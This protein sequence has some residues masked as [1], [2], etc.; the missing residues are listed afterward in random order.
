MQHSIAQYNFY[1]SR[2]A[3]L[4]LRLEQIRDA[5]LCDDMRL[6]DLVGASTPEAVARA[7]EDLTDCLDDLQKAYLAFG[8]VDVQ[9]GECVKEIG[10]PW[11]K[12]AS[13]LQDYDDIVS[14]D[15]CSLPTSL[16]REA[17]E[18]VRAFF[19]C[20]LA[21]S[22]CPAVGE[23][24][25][26][27][28]RAVLRATAKLAEPAA[29]AR[30][31]SRAVPT[32]FGMERR[33]GERLS[34]EDLVFGELC[35][36]QWGLRE[37][38]DS[39]RFCPDL[40]DKMDALWVALRD[41]S[42]TAID[43]SDLV[44]EVRASDRFRRWQEAYG[45]LDGFLRRHDELEFLRPLAGIERAEWL[46]MRNSERYEAVLAGIDSCDA[47]RLSDLDDDP[48][49]FMLEVSGVPLGKS[50]EAMSHEERLAFVRQAVEGLLGEARYEEDP[51]GDFARMESWYEDQLAEFRA[52]ARAWA[53]EYGDV[54]GLF[55]QYR[56]VRQGFFGAALPR[57][58]CKGFRATYGVW[59]AEGFDELADGALE[60]LLGER[61]LSRS[62]DD[63]LFHQTFGYLD[64]A[65]Y[66]MDVLLMQ[67]MRHNG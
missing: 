40:F 67:R 58:A 34:H 5:M 57:G 18:L 43:S 15:L 21:A 1:R 30:A 16:D 32:F 63:D 7:A 12:V 28:L 59:A 13:E 37:F 49:F 60:S 56:I 53:H 41:E 26:G 39:T 50:W 36:G 51:D 38:V 46:G 8:S 65:K 2:R 4:L 11:P 44:D 9:A 52:Q 23:G 47:Q 61:G 19:Y 24:T 42:P 17:R 54:D 48:D 25:V 62:M 27:G 29:T 6:E 35:M 3:R 55:E 22:M 64:E 45:E 33:R 20:C 31:D 66:L 14:A 10:G